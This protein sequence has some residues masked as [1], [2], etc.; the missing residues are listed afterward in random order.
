M[1][2]AVE[3]RIFNRRNFSGDVMLTDETGRAWLALPADNL[4]SN[5]M[6]IQTQIAF[7]RG[8]RLFLRLV[9]E[10]EAAP[11]ALPAEV[12]RRIEKK[13]PSGTRQWGIGVRFLH[14]SVDEIMQIERF[15]GT[16]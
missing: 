2:K 5:G 10:K 7:P 13:T 11:L 8:M 12:L 15:L 16:G 9:L 6:G 1:I 3:K 14:L 4:S